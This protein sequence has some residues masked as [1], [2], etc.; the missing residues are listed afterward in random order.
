MREWPD[1]AVA[2]VLRLRA[3]LGARGRESVE[4]IAA[5]ER[6]EDV[7]GDRGRMRRLQLELDIRAQEHEH[8]LA[9]LDGAEQRIWEMTDASDRNAARLAA[10]LAQ[11][12][13]QREQ[14]DDTLEELDVTRNLLAAAQAR[15]IE[16]E[17]LLA[18]ER[19]KLARVGLGAEQGVSNDSDAENVEELFAELDV[20]YRS[21]VDAQPILLPTAATRAHLAGDR[22]QETS[23]VPT[24][25]TDGGSS[26]TGSRAIELRSSPRVVVE[27]LSD[28]AWVAAGEPD[29][30]PD[31]ERAGQAEP[32]RGT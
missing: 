3:E 29:R 23:A 9:L 12:E 31:R 8:V 16:Q 22:R 1:E 5:R 21:S 15:T 24:A 14:L 17:R 13:K 4:V 11:L 28:D 32:K 6:V 30:E 10:G 2:E 26:G 19:A 27:P 20:G 25:V 7:V 18:S